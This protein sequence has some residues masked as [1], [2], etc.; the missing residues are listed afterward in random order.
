[1]KKLSVIYLIGVLFFFS[2]QEAIGQKCKFE[3]NEVD[4]ITGEKIVEVKAFIKADKKTLY[5]YLN[6]TDDKYNIRFI[7]RLGGKHNY[8]I[9]QGSKAIFKFDDGE[10]LE[11]FSESETIPTYNANDHILSSYRPTYNIPKEAIKKMSE[12]EVSFIRIYVSDKLNLDFNIK[13]KMRVK[14]QKIVVCISQ[15]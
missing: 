11:L 15:A 10:V 14:F 13:E 3:K 6:R 5:S 12:K 7:I 1:M 9:P 8:T 2:N 4:P